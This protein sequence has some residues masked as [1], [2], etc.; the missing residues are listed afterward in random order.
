MI[1]DGWKLVL[2][3]L[4][5]VHFDLIPGVSSWLIDDTCTLL[6]NLVSILVWCLFHQFVN[7]FWMVNKH[8]SD[9]LYHF[10]NKTM[11]M[12]YLLFMFF[13]CLIINIDSICKN[14]DFM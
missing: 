7:I 13:V 5:K 1:S 9:C 4:S 10:E 8:D 14:D 3:V 12:R 6:L 11:V 2:L